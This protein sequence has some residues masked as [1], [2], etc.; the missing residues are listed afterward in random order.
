M[1]IVRENLDTLN[2]VITVTVS[3]EDYS[4]K[5]ENELKKVARKV[6]MP[7]FRPGM[8][9]KGMVR[10]MYYISILTDEVGRM[11]I[12]SLFAYLRDEKINFLGEPLIHDEKQKPLDWENDSEFEFCYEL[13]LSPEFTL[14]IP[15][16]TF[17]FQ[18]I[19]VAEETL[20]ENIENLAKRYG[21]E[22]KG[23]NIREGDLISGEF[24]E[25]DA[26][27]NALE[28]GIRKKVYFMYDRIPLDT[29]KELLKDIAVGSIVKF[30][31]TQA[32][33]DAKT[34]SIYM[35]IPENEIG[36]LSANF[37]F[38]ILEISRMSPSEINQ[39]FYDRLFGVGNVTTEEEFRSKLT[40]ILKSD[41]QNESNLKLLNDIREGILKVNKL[42]LPEKF[43]R[44]WLIIKNEGKYTEEDI[45]RMFSQDRNIICWD[46]IRN[47][48]AK[49]NG[50]Q[51]ESDE[52]SARARAMVSNRFSEMGMPV[53]D[54]DLVNSYAEKVLSNEE[55]KE[56][57]SSL[58]LE[59]KT[60]SY[61]STLVK[62]NPVPVDY[63]EFWASLQSEVATEV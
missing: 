62:T 20:N 13:G 27:G 21:Q 51:V 15:D 37:N 4:E 17:D 30:H 26:D 2:A 23:E 3:K 6:S 16:D 54:P 34:A 12:N 10:K 35:G 36:N 8:V 31:P 25:T 9:P 1:K 32:F 7:G 29:D 19:V 48:V 56:K 59:Q 57:I 22:A 40:E 49:E 42:D 44:R 33:A 18:D 43:L 55:E 24:V 46:I 11:A 61:L 39:D 52:I 38:E 53:N 50:I 47:R 45:D 58:I 60:L 41:A 5:V 28:D 14:Q 63:K